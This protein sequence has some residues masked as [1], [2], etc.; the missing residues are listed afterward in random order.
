MKVS[1]LITDPIAE[2]NGVWVDI[3][4]GGQLKIARAGNPA[5]ARCY[6]RLTAEAGTDKLTEAQ[7]LDI[8]IEL[9]ANTILLDWSGLENDDGSSIPYSKDKAKELL[10]YRDFRALVQTHANNQAAFRFAAVKEAAA[11]LTKSP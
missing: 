8:L 4:Q 11:T 5:A 2:I 1:Q 9:L 3:G 10:G 6:E 7:S